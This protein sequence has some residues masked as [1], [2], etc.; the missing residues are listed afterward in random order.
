[1][2]T[3]KHIVVAGAGFAG[4]AAAHKLNN[5]DFSVTVLEARRRVGG[6]VWSEELPN[7][8]IV[9]LTNA[10]FQLALIFGSGMLPTERLSRLLTSAK[11]IVSPSIRYGQWTKQ[12]SQ[13]PR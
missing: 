3:K 9:A 7:G 13:G 8:A 11:R 12:V 5:R 10:W 1:M 6:R 2:S 4:L